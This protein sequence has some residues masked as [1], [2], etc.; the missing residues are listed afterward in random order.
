MIEGDRCETGG[1]EFDVLQHYANPGFRKVS[2]DT[3]L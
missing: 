2:Q 1:R 3:A